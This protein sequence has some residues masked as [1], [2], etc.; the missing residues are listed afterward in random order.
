MQPDPT[1]FISI[2]LAL[3]FPST[4]LFLAYP[5]HPPVV[6]YQLYYYSENYYKH[7]YDHL[8]YTTRYLHI[9]RYLRITAFTTRTFVVKVQFF[10]FWHSKNYKL[11]INNTFFECILIIYILYI[12][13][14]IYHITKYYTVQPVV[15]FFVLQN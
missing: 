1:R 3:L 4:V 9:I 11:L 7:I 15:T 8:Y 10:F 12:C 13:I 14:Y 5:N 2:L 6:D